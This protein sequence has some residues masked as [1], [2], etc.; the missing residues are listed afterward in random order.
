MSDINPKTSDPQY[1][2]TC[3]TNTPKMTALFTS[4]QHTLNLFPMESLIA[5]TNNYNKHVHDP[6]SAEQKFYE[7]LNNQDELAVKSEYIDNPDFNEGSS[8]DNEEQIKT[9]EYWLNHGTTYQAIKDTKYSAE[10][11]YPWQLP[12]EKKTE[13]ANLKTILDKDVQFILYW[14]EKFR[15]IHDT[16]KQEYYE[17]NPQDTPGGKYNNDNVY[18]NNFNESMFLLHDSTFIKD[19]TTSLLID[20]NSATG[21]PSIYNKCQMNNLDVETYDTADELSKLTTDKFKNNMITC[22]ASV[23]VDNKEVIWTV[24]DQANNSGATAITYTSVDSRHIS[25]ETDTPHGNNL[26]ADSKHPQRVK[27]NLETVQTKM[28]EI[29]GDMKRVFDFLDKNTRDNDEQWGKSNIN[30]M[31]EGIWGVVDQ[32]LGELKVLAANAPGSKR[33]NQDLD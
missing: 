32:N 28:N 7:D 21:A 10:P 11:N 8:G 1:V 16:V 20:K 31:I 2:D 6:V 25:H 23:K 27:A 22:A 15:C 29:L 5:Y 4:Y 13:E 33:R 30:Y 24:S 18:F 14:V 17:N 12:G 3:L 9:D 26:V 19:R